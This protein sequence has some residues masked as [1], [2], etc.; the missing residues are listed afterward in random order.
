MR[1]PVFDRIRARLAAGATPQQLVTEGFKRSSIYK[2]RRQLVDPE[3]RPYGRAPKGWRRIGDNAYEREDG[4]WLM[5]NRWMVRR[6]SPTGREGWTDVLAL[7]QSV[8]NALVWIREK[9]REEITP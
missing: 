9:E 1:S 3:A 7:V 2:V 8:S 5:V 4:H 6:G